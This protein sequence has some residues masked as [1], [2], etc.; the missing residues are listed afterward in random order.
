MKS[1]RLLKGWM[2]LAVC[3]VVL[4]ARQQD[5]PIGVAQSYY[6]TTTSE[7][8]NYIQMRD[9]LKLTWVLAW[10]GNSGIHVTTDYNS[11]NLKV[12]TYRDELTSI[13]K[14]QRMIYEAG[15][16]ANNGL[17]NY[18]SYHNDMAYVEGN[19]LTM[20]A[21]DSDP[22]YLVYGAVPSV[23]FSYNPTSTYHATFTMKIQK[24]G[25]P[26][27]VVAVLYVVCLTHNNNLAVPVTLTEGSFSANNTYQD[28]D[29]PFS[30][31]YQSGQLPLQMY[32]CGRD[33]LRTSQI[34]CSSIDVRV[35]L[36]GTTTT[37]LAK[38]TLEDDQSKTLFT[39]GKDTQ[40]Q[41]E[42]SIAKNNYPLIQRISLIDEPKVAAYLPFHYV[43][44][45]LQS[46]FGGGTRGRANT[47]TFESG[48]GLQ[49]LINDADP[50]EL[51]IDPYKINA[52]VPVPTSL[53]SAGDASSLGI[54]AYT[55]D[56]A[57]T[58]SIQ[59]KADLMVSALNDACSISSSAGK[60]LWFIP[61]L[62]GEYIVNSGQYRW[63]TG[64]EPWQGAVPLRPPTGNEI[65][66]EVN[67]AI[68][69]GAKGIIGY[70][71]GTEYD[72]NYGG[73]ESVPQPAYNTGLTSATKVNG[74]YQNHW[75][76]YET[77]PVTGNGTKSVWTG[78]QE[79][80]DAYSTVNGQLQQIS[81]ILTTLSWQGTKSW[82]SGT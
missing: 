26:N 22:G 19:T 44:N 42:A 58:T 66:M 23:P 53:L 3:S 55:S 25:Y 81:S 1:A 6:S 38:V 24:T 65:K 31:Q 64:Q 15:R 49:R 30:L 33:G 8:V 4:Q 67:L 82:N 56:Q 79:K 69:H 10:G 62:H 75:S 70:P 60:A 80:W 45:I 46:V 39:G 9:S 21:Y 16:L 68:A 36:Q 5:F 7:E 11:A 50:Y 63:P 40:I 47:T 59:A 37:T 17:Y 52:D 13:T 29:V 43:D 34:I 77:L 12:I 48:N 18:F 14:S 32:L 73:T 2:V 28:F 74:Y 76:N 27:N 20:Y 54:A 72:A 41:S 35:W 78:Y 57:Y 61:Q 71:F 51:Q